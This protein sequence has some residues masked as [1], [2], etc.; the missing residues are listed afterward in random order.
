MPKNTAI[1]SGFAPGKLILTGEHAVVYGH[2][3]IAMA[4]D[5]GTHISV[6]HQP[7]PIVV[8]SPPGTPFHDGRLR[9]A[10]APL[11]GTSGLRITI[12]SEIPI[13][14]GMGSSA[15]LSVSLVRALADLAGRTA[16]LDECRE[17]GMLVERGFHGNPS[18]VDHTVSAMGGAIH[19]RNAES[20]Q[21]PILTSISLPPLRW[22]VLDSGSSGDTA[23]MVQKVRSRVPHNESILQSIGTITER[24]AQSLPLGDAKQLGSLLFRNHELLQELGVSTPVLDDLVDFARQNGALG[25]KLAGAGGGGVVLALVEAQQPLLHAAQ[26]RGVEAFS[27]GVF[28]TK[29]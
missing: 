4:I 5:R 10:M 12:R 22:V 17:R 14:R 23:Q 28:P 20:T 18:G 13:G 2:G 24:I 9:K 26:D 27:V 6:E 25:A 3:A 19:F 11:T 7:G 21:P 1:G 8:H 15:A 29:G 16:T